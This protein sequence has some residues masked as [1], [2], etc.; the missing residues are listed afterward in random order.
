VDGFSATAVI[1]VVTAPAVTDILRGVD[2]AVPSNVVTTIVSYTNSLSTPF[3]FDGW[4][5]TSQ[6]EGDWW[7]YIDMAIVDEDRDSASTMRAGRQFSSPIRVEPGSII[8]IKAEHYNGSTG[9]FA[10][11]IFGHR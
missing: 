4:S 3:F 1:P 11:T 7:V 10:A 6:H 9:Q 2:N 8:D 5:G